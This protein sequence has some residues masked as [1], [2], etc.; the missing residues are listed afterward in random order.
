MVNGAETVK[1][2]GVE[3]AQGTVARHEV[4]QREDGSKDYCVWLDNG[5][6]LEYQEQKKATVYTDGNN[7]TSIFGL[8]S[9][10]VIGNREQ[11]NII[12]AHETENMVYDLNDNFAD[13]VTTIN[14]DAK[15]L[16]SLNQL[17]IT[18]DKDSRQH[19]IYK[20]KDYSKPAEEGV[21]N[22]KN[23]KFKLDFE[24]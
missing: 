17:F 19:K 13:V 22:G 4:K 14:S 9:A 3:Y 7:T 23:A 8:K 10:T 15:D 5:V 1:I 6:K 21:F 11:T 20:N 12:S 16:R 24:S 2:G 18:D